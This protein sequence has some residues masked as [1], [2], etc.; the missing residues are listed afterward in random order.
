MRISRALV[1]ATILL[2]FVL[3]PASAQAQFGSPADARFFVGIQAGGATPMTDLPDGTRILTGAAVGMTAGTWFT[4]SVGVRGNLLWG[5]TSARPASLEAPLAR[6]RPHVLQYGGDVLVR[7]PGIPEGPSDWG[8]YAIGG[9][10][11]KTWS[12]N[13]NDTS[14]TGLAGNLG[15]GLAAQPGS[16]DRWGLQL[17][18]RNFMSQFE[19][20]GMERTF[21][22][23]TWTAGA[24]FHL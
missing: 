23:L 18:V 17:E 16:S 13:G 10:G 19:D 2:A 14:T 15:V 6:E 24:I 4:P 7:I 11:A 22:D 20:F 5:R 12:W 9:I 3:V 8:L 1:T 21:H